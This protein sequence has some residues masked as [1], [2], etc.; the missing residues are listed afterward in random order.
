MVKTD[1]CPHPH[2]LAVDGVGDTLTPPAPGDSEDSGTQLLPDSDLIPATERNAS[3]APASSLGSLKRGDRLDKYLI[4]DIL[5]RG[6]MGVV[7]KAK[8]T[9]L[10]R[11]VAIKILGPLLADSLPARKRFI[12]EGQSAAAV[13]HP[14]IVTIYGVEEH[15][16]SPYLVLE[17]IEGG[18][19]EELVARS[20]PLPVEDVVNLGLQVAEGLAAAHQRGLIHR[21][22]KPANILL[23]K[24]T[25]RVAIA[26]FG[27]ARAA[28]DATISRQGEVCGTPGFMAPEQVTG[29]AVGP[30]ADLF[31]LG[32]VLYY[33]CTGTLPFEAPLSMAVLHRVC[34]DDPRPIHEINKDVPDWL[35]ELIDG[36]LAKDPDQRIQ[37]AVEIIEIFR[38]RRTSAS[39]TQVM[40]PAAD[41]V[42]TPPP[43]RPAYAFILGGVFL[44]SLPAFYLLFQEE[45]KRQQPIVQTSRK[46][47]ANDSTK[48]PP[49]SPPQKTPAAPPKEPVE[50]PP[51]KVNPRIPTPEPEPRKTKPTPVEAKGVVWVLAKDPKCV[52]FFQEEGL[53]VRNEKTH[54]VVRLS[55]GRNELPQGDYHL[56]P[57]VSPPGIKIGPRRFTLTSTTEVL[58]NLTRVT[59]GDGPST[60]GLEPMGPPP[61]G[62]PFPPPPPPPHG[63][64]LRRGG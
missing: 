6:G 28:D 43:A 12:R 8:D 39:S 16:S 13:K 48:T 27:L 47:L 63:P 20:A 21:D 59:T 17:Y 57:D 60:T 55:V 30:R 31:S 7:F 23:E 42:P 34:E 40:P 15:Q 25:G 32:S 3:V 62:P 56:D 9:I 2:L 41:P 22:I 61:F 5:G 1:K 33:M 4:L 53:S 29:G 35:V 24:E 19:L 11:T 26:D 49:E 10:D 18:N 37:T 51:P 52:A 14:H 44:L 36:L 54:A 50:T 46:E 45:E 38:S 58:L 64:P